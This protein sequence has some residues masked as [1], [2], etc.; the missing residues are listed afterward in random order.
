MYYYREKHG[1]NT[2]HVPYSNGLHRIGKKIILCIFIYMFAS[3]LIRGHP[4][5]VVPGKL[6]KLGDATPD[7]IVL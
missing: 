4:V 6:N 1:F 7:T 2:L 5:V 3:Q